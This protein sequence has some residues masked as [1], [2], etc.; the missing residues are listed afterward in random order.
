MNCKYSQIDF[1]I[2]G[3]TFKAWVSCI[4]LIVTKLYYVLGIFYMLW[5]VGETLLIAPA[6]SKNPHMS[7]LDVMGMMK[8]GGPESE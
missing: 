6:S 3:Q 2:N 4:N 5:V 8:K 1:L 7:S